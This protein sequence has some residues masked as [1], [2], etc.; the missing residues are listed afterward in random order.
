MDNSNLSSIS[1]IDVSADGHLL[2][3]YQHL[4]VSSTFLELVYR[5]GVD[6]HH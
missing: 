1:N 3:A 5:A 6:I 2:C 4:Q